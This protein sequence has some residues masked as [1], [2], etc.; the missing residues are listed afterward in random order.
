VIGRIFGRTQKE[1]TE[2]DIIM[3]LSPRILYKPTFSETDMKSFSVG[4]DSSPLLFEV[5]PAVQPVMPPQGPVLLPTPS[6]RPE[7]IRAPVP[8]PTPTPHP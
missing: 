5:P 1:A 2:T 4:S 3:T 8:A 6:L 7:P